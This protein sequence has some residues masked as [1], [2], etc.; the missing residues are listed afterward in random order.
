MPPL[1][2]HANGALA[3]TR[4]T[5]WQTV[6]GLILPDTFTVQIPVPAQQSWTD[7]ELNREIQLEYKQVMF[8]MNNTLSITA[9]TCNKNTNVF[10]SLLWERLFAWVWWAIGNTA[11]PIVWITH[12]NVYS[13]PYVGRVSTSDS[14]HFSLATE[15]GHSWP[16]SVA[17]YADGLTMNKNKTKTHSA[18]YNIFSI[19]LTQLY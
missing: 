19:N 4:H 17:I 3:L 14:I 5:D 6:Q 2:L 18:I 15:R 1:V 10:L 16:P 12:Y 13:L 9:L 8:Q 11:P 7:M